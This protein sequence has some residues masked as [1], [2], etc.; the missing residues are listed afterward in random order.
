MFNVPS[1]NFKIANETRQKIL[2]LI[3]KSLDYIKPS[4]FY[5]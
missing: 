2:K 5:T 1:N 4:T 3:G